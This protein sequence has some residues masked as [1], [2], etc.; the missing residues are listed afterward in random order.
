LENICFT[1]CRK[2]KKNRNLLNVQIGSV[3]ILLKLVHQ[4]IEILLTVL[5]DLSSFN[6]FCISINQIIVEG[7]LCGW[8]LFE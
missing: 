2:L 6:G 7:S 4:S 3:N 8:C 1:E 5:F